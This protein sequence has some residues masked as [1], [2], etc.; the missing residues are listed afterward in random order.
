MIGFANILHVAQEEVTEGEYRALGEEAFS[1]G[2]HLSTMLISIAS[3][4]PVGAHMESVSVAWLTERQADQQRLAEK[5]RSIE[6]ELCSKLSKY[7]VEDVYIESFQIDNIVGRAAMLAD[8]V[9]IGQSIVSDP[10]TLNAVLDGA[11]FHARVPVLMRPDASA[12]FDHSAVLIAWSDTAESAAAAK[13]SVPMLKKAMSV[14]IVSVDMPED[15][16]QSLS[17]L[18][19]YLTYHGVNSSIDTVSS[20]GLT[21]AECLTDYADRLNSDV[22]V[23]GAY[24]HAR[25]RETIFGGVTRSMVD[26]PRRALFLAR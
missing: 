5:A 15:R 18:H 8:L 1:D 23:M 26:R 24:G 13:A 19:N 14:Q 16:R 3:V 12:Q 21:I 22:I 9:V 10:S 20:R 2:S 11:L 25:L 6:T 7:A 17:E 4:P